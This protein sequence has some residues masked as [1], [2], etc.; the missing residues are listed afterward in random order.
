MAL[1]SLKDRFKRL[2]K[3]PF[4]L[5]VAIAASIQQSWK[6]S[7]FVIIYPDRDGDWVNRQREAIFVSP[8]LNVARYRT[9]LANVLDLWCFKCPLDAGDT[10]VD[11]GAGIGDEAVAFSKLVGQSGRVLAIEAHPRTY[12]CLVKTIRA[13]GLRNVTAL[14]IAVLDAEGE[15]SISDGPEFLANT[16]LGQNPGPLIRGAALDDIA[17]EA[18]ISRPAFIKMNI[19]GAEAMAV[20]GMRELLANG[21]TIVISC[22]DF[23]ADSY[24]G[25]PDFRTRAKVFEALHNA[26]Y[27]ITR[28]CDDTRDYVRDYLYGSRNSPNLTFQRLAPP[29][30]LSVAPMGFG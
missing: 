17:R 1:R 15:I 24:G 3:G 6:H 2:Q 7:S 18:G 10:V 11:V 26:G 8:E 20:K 12:R 29:D 30:Q 21:S 28:R 14:N 27:E 9:V 5:V 25:G 13:N 22:H 19:E 4:R 16:I 23:I